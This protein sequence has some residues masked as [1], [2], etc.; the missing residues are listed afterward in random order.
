MTCPKCG[1]GLMEKISYCVGQ[2][3]LA[4]NDEQANEHLHATCERCGYSVRMPCADAG[5]EGGNNP[6]G[7]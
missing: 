6:C 2:I 1:S 3:C 5:G 4:V 7:F